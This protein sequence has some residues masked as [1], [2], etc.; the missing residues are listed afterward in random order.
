MFWSRNIHSS[1]HIGTPIFI[2]QPRLS[3]V[4]VL[5]EYIERRDLQRKDSDLVQHD[6]YRRGNLEFTKNLSWTII[7][8]G[9]NRILRMACY[10][11]IQALILLKS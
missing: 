4:D 1:R 10:A 5:A 2:L 11:N 3:H 9:A 7:S 6:V 8:T